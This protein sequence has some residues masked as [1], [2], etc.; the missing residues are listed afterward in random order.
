M[1]LSLA[2]AC[3]S[4]ALADDAL[5]FLLTAYLLLTCAVTCTILLTGSCTTVSDIWVLSISTSFWYL[6]LYVIS[7]IPFWPSWIT[8]FVFSPVVDETSFVIVSKGISTVSFTIFSTITPSFES[9]ISL[10]SITSDVVS[11]DVL[12]TFSVPFL[13]IV[14]VLL[15]SIFSS[16][17]GVTLSS[18]KM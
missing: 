16:K 14:I 17:L 18:S 4:A 3:A 12:C 15:E 9:N 6:T 10:L 1:H 8:L 7:L 2:Y 5:R 13:D 11:S